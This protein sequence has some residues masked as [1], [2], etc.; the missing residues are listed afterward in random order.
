[1]PTKK[2][3]S[4]SLALMLVES[5]AKAPF[6]VRLTDTPPAGEGW[7][8]F[9]GGTPGDF[10]CCFRFQG[11]D[12]E[13][14]VAILVPPPG[15]ATIPL[16]LRRKIGLRLTIQV[17]FGILHVMLGDLF[18]KLTDKRL[19]KLEDALGEAIAAHHDAIV[20]E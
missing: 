18:D 6:R 3:F 15:A 10:G 12:A 1:M 20:I 16:E 11:L 8:V 13:A 19:T 17:K 9:H 2:P 14:E 5:I 4:N 7:R